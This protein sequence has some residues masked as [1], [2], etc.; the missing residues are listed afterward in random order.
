MEQHGRRPFRGA[1]PCCFHCSR[2]GRLRLAVFGEAV[3]R[4]RVDQVVSWR[5]SLGRYGPPVFQRHTRPDV[6]GARHSPRT[7]A[8]SPGRF[9]K[10][11]A[12]STAPALTP[13]LI[14]RQGSRINTPRPSDTR[15]WSRPALLQG[16]GPR[17]WASERA[18]ESEPGGPVRRRAP[19]KRLGPASAG[20]SP[21]TPTGSGRPA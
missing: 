12:V 16:K 13:F 10:A 21:F 3:G 9:H 6:T 18:V 7:G 8:V 20:Y 15:C 11:T 19:A 2:A 17:F 1:V 4:L 14:H 5:P